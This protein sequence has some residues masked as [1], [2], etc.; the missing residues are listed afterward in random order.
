MS[1]SMNRRFF[2]KAG[3][4]AVAAY[5][6]RANAQDTK[7]AAGWQIG[8]YTR[9]WSDY[10][11]TVALDAIAEAGFNYAGLMTTKSDT[12][13]VISVKTTLDEAKKIGEECKKRGLSAPSV[14]GGGIPVE[15]SIEAGVK[16]MKQLIDNCAAAGVA[17]LMMGGVGDAKLHEPYYTAIRESCPYA[18]EKGVGISVKP[19][20]GSNST[21]PQCR[22]IIDFVGH[23]SFRLWYD[24]GNIFYYSDG[25]LDPVDDAATVDGLVAGMSV[26]D[27]QLPKEVMLTPGTG[28]VDFPKV[29]ARL[30]QGGFTSGPLIIECLKPGDLPGLLAE[31]KKARQFV[32]QLVA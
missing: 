31:A 18:A 12:H 16:G 21:G 3:A 6:C 30:K 25:K 15:E 19:H 32:E 4:A 27:F 29:M 17:N 14:Y 13:L 20:G 10:E 22:K 1:N 28:K 7:P 9:P 23:K 2:L 26:K 5:A 11:Y 24:P 8:C